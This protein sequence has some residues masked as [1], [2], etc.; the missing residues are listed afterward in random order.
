MTKL[1]THPAGPPA[2]EVRPSSGGMRRGT[3]K[4]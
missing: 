3:S 2:A 1:L 4:L